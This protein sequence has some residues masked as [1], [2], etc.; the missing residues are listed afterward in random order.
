MGQLSS[1]VTTQITMKVAAVL[2][3]VFI[4]AISAK[5]DPK[6]FFVSTSSTTSTVSTVT[7]CFT[8]T[9]TPT[10]CTGRKKRSISI[11]D[12]LANKDDAKIVDPSPLES[13]I[14]EHE[15]EAKS[16]RQGKFLMY[17]LTT[18]TTSFTSTAIVTLVCTASPNPLT[19]CPAS[20]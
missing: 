12:E 5:R 6:L 14:A 8:T 20:G 17:W 3:L 13:S 16:Q 1:V 9:A 19:I 11:V 4:S 15:P 7:T 10:A 2:S 18:T